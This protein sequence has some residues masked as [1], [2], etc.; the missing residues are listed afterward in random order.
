MSLFDRIFR[1]KKEPLEIP[2][3]R[4]A[5]L[6]DNLHADVISIDNLQTNT[7]NMSDITLTV[8]QIHKG[9]DYLKEGSA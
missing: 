7:I 9:I 3:E 1:R 8:E 6:L 4:I 2:Y 5:E